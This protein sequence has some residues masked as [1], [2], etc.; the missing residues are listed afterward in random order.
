[1]TA[2]AGKAQVSEQH[3]LADVARVT[4]SGSELI[5]AIN[6]GVGL[7]AAAVQEFVSLCVSNFNEGSQCKKSF[8]MATNSCLEV[9]G[10]KSK[11][12]F[13]K[14]HKIAG[15][16]QK[17]TNKN[18]LCGFCDKTFVD[19]DASSNHMLRVHNE[20][21]VRIVSDLHENLSHPHCYVP[22]ATRHQI[23]CLQKQKNITTKY[24][25]PL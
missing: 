5:K 4:E 24:T 20:D 15:A 14:F 23:L 12:S 2:N 17:Q 11:L 21:I 7:T 3:I 13:E 6:E 16:Q 18:M 19:F 8:L 1:M 25:S 10:L 22:L 9:M